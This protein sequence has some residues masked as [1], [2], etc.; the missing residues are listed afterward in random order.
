MKI[1]GNTA[2]IEIKNNL[3]YKIISDKHK[4]YKKELI[5]REVYWLKKLSHLDFIPKLIKYDE[6]TI[7]MSYCGEPV[8]NKNKPKDY[9]IQL[10][11][12]KTKIYENYCFYNDWK[13]GN[14]LVKDGKLFLIDFGW[15]SLIREDYTC[16]KNVDST[17]KCKVSGN[18]FL[19]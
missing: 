12:I 10:N 1:R 16:D 9:Y 17:L 2:N 6:N 7:V 19:L 5:E 11:T 3:V 8:S 13:D 18:R 4:K 14:L 15:C